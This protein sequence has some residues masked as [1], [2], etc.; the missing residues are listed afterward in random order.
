MNHDDELRQIGLVVERLEAR[1][2]GLRPERVEQIV[3]AAYGHFHGSGVRDF[4]PLLVER[5]A[6]Q[7]IRILIA[8]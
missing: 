1:H 4:V 7:T 5:S 3:Q 6:N 8:S 2:T